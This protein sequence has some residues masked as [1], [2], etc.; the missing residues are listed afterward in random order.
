MGRPGYRPD[1]GPRARGITGEQLEAQPPLGALAA[2]TLV[3]MWAA[4][5]A[6]VVMLAYVVGGLIAT[7]D[8][9]PAGIVLLGV[10]AF[11][12]VM[13]WPP[14]FALPRTWRRGD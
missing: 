14:Q 5:T 10:A 11:V 3:S 13:L 9:L 12:H 4:L 7:A 1:R 6:A 2:S 8:Y